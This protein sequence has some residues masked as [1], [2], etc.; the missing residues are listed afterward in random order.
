MGPLVFDGAALLIGLTAAVIDARTG[1]IPNWLTLPA[2][3]VALVLHLILGG[4]HRLGLSAAGFLLGAVV[5][6]VLYYVTSGRAIGGGDVKLFAA[7]GALRGP[8]EG[9]EIELSACILV[10]VFSLV[11]LAFAGRLF[12]VLVNALFI[13]VN[14]LL[15][16]KWKRPLAAEALTAT[17]M[18]PAIAAAVAYVCAMDHAP[19]WVSWLA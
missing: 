13:G 16:A 9:L 7:L 11:R 5:P 18:G 2:A 12:A 6:G 14:P 19:R 3:L 8:M 15:P 17:R 10:A 4:A 1:R